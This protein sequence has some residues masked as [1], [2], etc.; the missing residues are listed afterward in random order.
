MEKENSELV[1]NQTNSFRKVK[2][3]KVPQ[4]VTVVL[5]LVGLV[6]FW[7]LLYL[8]FPIPH[9]L[10]PSPF[11]IAERMYLDAEMLFYHSLVTLEEVLLGFAISVVFGIPLAVLIVYSKYFA[12]TIY[13]ILVGIHCIPM[14]SLAPLLVIWFGYSMTTKV[15]IACLISVFPVIINAVV[16]MQSM[17]KEMD[18]LARSLRASNLQTF[19]YFR[20]PKALPSIFGGF[21]V[22]ITLAVVGAVVAE[23]VA[24]ERGLGYLQLVAN[25]QLDTTLEFCALFLL[26]FMGIGLFYLVELVGRFAMPW[27]RGR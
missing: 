13:P 11:S 6:G 16:G 5:T 4:W 14:V 10:L 21:K 23:F 20:L 8:V 22:G 18:N 15:M 27:K 3:K 7:Q 24:S 25:S 2:I 1:L 26:A 9:Y 17:D 19:L 12:N